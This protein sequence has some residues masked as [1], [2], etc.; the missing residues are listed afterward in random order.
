MLLF[1]PWLAVI[2]ESTSAENVRAW[3]FLIFAIAALAAVILVG[4]LLFGRRIHHADLKLGSI[5][6]AV[7]GIDL[8]ETPLIDKVRWLEDA[9]VKI[10]EHLEIDKPPQHRR[11]DPNR[12]D[13]K[14]DHR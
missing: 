2:P 13:R 14:D 8:G 7:N 10:L 3:S 9:V 11:R 1:A 4:A 6:M 5:A 12:R